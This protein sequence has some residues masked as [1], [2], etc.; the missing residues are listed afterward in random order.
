MTNY[1]SRI[2]PAPSVRSKPRRLDRQLAGVGRE[3]GRDGFR[4]CLRIDPGGECR[5]IED[6]W[7]PFMERPDLLV[8]ARRDDGAGADDL[9]GRRDPLLPQAGEREDLNADDSEGVRHACAV[10]RRL[11][12]RKYRPTYE[13]PRIRRVQGRLHP[14]LPINR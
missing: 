5:R 3:Q 8:G 10:C 7:H 1:R 14:R 11:A 13:R 9:A 4:R 12:P 6:Y 2:P